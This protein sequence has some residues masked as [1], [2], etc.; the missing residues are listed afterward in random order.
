MPKPVFALIECEKAKQSHVWSSFAELLPDGK[1]IVGYRCGEVALWDSQSGKTLKAAEIDKTDPSH[2]AWI[3]QDRRTLAFIT[4]KTILAN[5]DFLE[6]K[7]PVQYKTIGK[8]YLVDTGSLKVQTTLP[9]PVS[10]V[11]FSNDGELWAVVDEDKTVRVLRRGNNQELASRKLS[12]IVGG[13]AF[14]ADPAEL[15]IVESDV[16]LGWNYRANKVRPGAKVPGSKHAFSPDGKYLLH[17][18]GGYKA[19]SPVVTD[20]TTWKSKQLGY[21]GPMRNL[22]LSADGTKLAIAADNSMVVWSLAE[23]RAWLKWKKPHHNDIRHTAFS[24]DGQR[25]A[26]VMNHG[27]V[28]LFDFRAG[29]TD[30]EVAR[31]Q[32]KSGERQCLRMVGPDDQMD[33]ESGHLE[34]LNAL[35]VACPACKRPDLSFVTS[36]YALGKKIEAPVDFAPAVAGNFLV[37]ESMKRVLEAVAPELC[38]FHPTIH[39]RT[40]QPTPWCLAVPQFTQT[41]AEPSG[42]K[43]AKCGE[44]S[45][46]KDIVE[47]TS[48]PISKHEV[49]KAHNSSRDDERDLYFSVRL[50]TLVKKLG[51]RGMV[52]SYDCRQEPTAEDL[53][54]V[55]ATVKQLRPAKAG[56]SPA[57]A[58]G[59]VATWFK[60]Y[61]EKKAKAKTAGHDFATVEKKHRVV[62]PKAYKVFITQLGSKSFKDIDGEEGFRATVL[63]PKKL[64][65]EACCEEGADEEDSFKGILFATTDHGDAFYFDTTR[66]R[67]DY[68]VRKH[69]HEVGT[70]EPYA[71]N[72]AECIK[73]FAGA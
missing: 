71:K 15:W 73:R 64:V 66:G 6:T 9:Y 40:K 42:K 38:R 49:F 18:R 3:S 16:V 65:F 20:T 33:R 55:Q 72:F 30:A 46:W 27:Q 48:N 26:C 2:E 58:D 17:T 50:E 23:N 53:T 5:E 70:F 47:T 35:P 39:R 28:Y 54:W 60:Q 12:G 67:P 45:Q 43:C 21:S 10:Q 22:S 4:S 25:I 36:P 8:T 13:L 52:R 59:E 24:A 31:P 61:L 68:E 37:R 19:S 69:D 51:L 7:A 44:P 63:P 14:Q 11:A 62:L 41:T 34:P 1:S 29:A 56:G 57:D 32:P